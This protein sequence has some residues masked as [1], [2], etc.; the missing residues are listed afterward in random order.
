MR[1]VERGELLQAGGQGPAGCWL[2]LERRGQEAGSRVEASAG[3]VGSFVSPPYLTALTHLQ[4]SGCQEGWVAV[5][6][7]AFPLAM[8]VLWDIGKGEA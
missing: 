3:R 7:Q 5:S 8:Q 2:W 1:R 6:W 4:G